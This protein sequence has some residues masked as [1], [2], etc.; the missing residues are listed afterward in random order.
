MRAT[1]R[2]GG[3]LHEDKIRQMVKYFCM[4]AHGTVGISI[5]SGM[6]GTREAQSIRDILMII[7]P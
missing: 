5:Y 2:G 6:A 7:V 3:I 1:G 4:L